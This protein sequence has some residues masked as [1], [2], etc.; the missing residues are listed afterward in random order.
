MTDSLSNCYPHY[1]QPFLRIVVDFTVLNIII[2]FFIAAG[3][4]LL[5]VCVCVWILR[6]IPK[7]RVCMSC[8]IPYKS[9]FIKLF[10][11]HKPMTLNHQ[12]EWLTRCAWAQASTSPPGR[13]S[14]NPSTRYYFSFPR[15]SLFLPSNPKQIPQILPGNPRHDP[16]PARYCLVIAQAEPLRRR[17]VGRR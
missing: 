4:S 14:V 16:S 6:K 7:S 17:W 10:P 8:L 13:L 3:V 1:C 5:C 15:L 2:I 11:H 12:R 9:S